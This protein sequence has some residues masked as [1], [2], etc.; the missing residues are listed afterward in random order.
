[1]SIE[2]L[3]TH[4]ADWYRPLPPEDD[5]NRGALGEV[6]DYFEAQVPATTQARNCRPDQNWSGSLQDFGPG[7]EQT[8]KRRW[9]LHRGFVGV[10]ERD[11]LDVTSGSNAPIRLRVLSVTPADTRRRLH[12]IEVNVE[13]FNDIPEL[14]PED[15]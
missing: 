2:R 8:G 11:V 14:V 3:F 10:A 15:S 12:H 13:V 4:H 5:R 1:M 7:E 6:L 9:F